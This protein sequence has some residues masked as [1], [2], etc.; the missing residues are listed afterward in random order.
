MAEEQFQERTEQATPRRREK[1]R[2]EGKVARSA[3]LNS[4]VILCLGAVALYFM[5]PIL[6]S[7]L[8]QFMIFIFQEA[9]RMHP[10]YDTMVALLTSKV[11]TFFFLL[12]PIL[13]VLMV[14]AYGINVMQVGFLFTG[15]P[16]EPKLDKLNIATGIKKLFSAR[17]L[18]ELIR[19]TAKVILIGF[20]GYKAIT[21]QMDSFFL[22]SDNSVGVF[23]GA[24]GQMA[25]KTT[26][27]IGAVMLVLAIFDYAYQKFDFEKSIR[28]SK[29][30]IRDEYKDTE[31]SPQIK[32]RV[33]QI[34]R[35][36]SRRRMMQ[37]IPNADVV[38][39]NPT[40]IAVALKYNSTEMDAPMVVAKG[41]RLIAEKIKEI[42]REAE[43]PVV[44]N[45]PLARALFSM[46]EVGSYVPAKLYRAVAEVLAY[47][48]RLKG[49]GV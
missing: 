30:D 10:D 2:E 15:K 17:S 42:A 18:V 16:L 4:A 43:V 6:V 47:V 31:G 49:V 28:M 19:D 41:E 3:E 38:V 13:L 1:A 46:C 21:A 34:Q 25:L 33:R 23:A 39:T 22:L 7:Q 5:G 12:G 20:V 48:Y 8:K 35:E 14:V 24:M 37:E 36:M 32:A 40:H 29:Q 9:P 44:E 26:L 11:M 45:P 27:Q